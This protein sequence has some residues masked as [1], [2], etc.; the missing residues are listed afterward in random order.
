[1][2][3]LPKISHSKCILVRISVDS[4]SS[5]CLSFHLIFISAVT[6]KPKVK[7]KFLLFEFSWQRCACYHA[8]QRIIKNKVELFSKSFIAIIYIPWLMSCVLLNLNVK[9]GKM[10]NVF[11]KKEQKIRIKSQC[12]YVWALYTS[13]LRNA[14]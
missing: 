8:S 1:M 7:K 13:H 3:S 14:V 11:W 5:I 2:K 10:L 9:S 4:S 12:V 6:Q